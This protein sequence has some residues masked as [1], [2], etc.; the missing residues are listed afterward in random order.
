[1]LFC[2]VQVSQIDIW[3]QKTMLTYEDCVALSSL[4]HDEIEAIAEHEQVPAIVAAEMGRYLV[5]QDDGQKVVKRIILE[6]IEVARAR[7]DVV[8]AACLR[9]VLQEFCTRCGEPLSPS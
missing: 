5:E 7:G 2:P 4:T 3:G 6:D 9:L 1:M 8:H